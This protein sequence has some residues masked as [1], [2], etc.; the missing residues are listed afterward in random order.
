MSSPNRWW[1]VPSGQIAIASAAVFLVLISMA[2]TKFWPRPASPPIDPTNMA[3]V[4]LGERLY[5]DQCSSCHGEKLQ[6]Q[7]NWKI[8]QPDGLMPAPPHDQTGH[9]WHHPDGVLFEVTKYGLVPPNAPEGYESTMPAFGESLSDAEIAAVLA[10]IK[11]TWPAKILE[12]QQ[13]VTVQAQQ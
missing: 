4:G 12:R 1:R 3:L 9:T 7:P 5:G 10:Y 13:R 6:G 11:S 2:L 8:R